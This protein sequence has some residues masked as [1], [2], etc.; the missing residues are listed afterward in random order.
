MDRTSFLSCLSFLKPLDDNAENK[1][2]LKSSS[3]SSSL[4]A[5]SKLEAAR[6]CQKQVLLGDFFQV[7]IEPTTTSANKSLGPAY[8]AVVTGEDAAMCSCRMILYTAILPNSNNS[9]HTTTTVMTPMKDQ[10]QQEGRR[11]TWLGGGGI[12]MANGQEDDDQENESIVLLELNGKWWYQLD[13]HQALQRVR[14]E[15]QAAA[16][17]NT[18]ADDE[19]KKVPPC[20]ILEFSSCWFRIFSSRH[21][22]DDDDDDKS[23]ELLNQAKNKLNEIRG[24]RQS[25]PFPF[26]IFADDGNSSTDPEET[27]SAMEPS[28]CLQS[29][30][31][32]WEDLDALERV[33]ANPVASSLQPGEIAQ[34]ERFQAFLNDKLTQIPRHIANTMVEEEDLAVTLD[35]AGLDIAQNH[36]ALNTTMDAFWKKKKKPLHYHHHLQKKRRR[37][38]QQEESDNEASSKDVQQDCIQQTQELLK[39]HK[40]ALEAKYRLATLPVRG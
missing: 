37:Q 33:L 38:Q 11:R 4:A 18:A 16:T 27:A 14:V 31:Q 12:V 17:T 21:N 23:M 19:T 35:Q 1:S 40:A 6:K 34:Q 30:Q 26:R 3:S 2:T 15:E 24:R 28:D 9:Q 8:F 5:L 36:D 22:D 10:Y 32:A 13:V 29:H 20:L 25:G 7:S 39:N